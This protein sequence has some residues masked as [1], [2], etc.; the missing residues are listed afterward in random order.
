MKGRKFLYAAVAL[1][2][3]VLGVGLYLGYGHEGE[4][5]R[6]MREAEKRGLTT[7]V[8]TIARYED[9][10]APTRLPLAGLASMRELTRYRFGSGNPE[11]LGRLV[12]S[13]EPFVPLIEDYAQTKG[14]HFDDWSNA[15]RVSVIKSPAVLGMHGYMAAVNGDYEK[16]IRYVRLIRR[17]A[18]K[19][20]QTGIGEMANTSATRWANI[21]LSELAFRLRNQPGAF[22]RL[23][24]LLDEHPVVDFKKSLVDELAYNLAVIDDI[25]NGDMP[26]GYVADSDFLIYDFNKTDREFGRTRVDL[27]KLI[28]SRYDNWDNR[29]FAVD[30][31]KF[32]VDLQDRNLHDSLISQAASST[33]WAKR[34]ELDELAARC[35][36]NLTLA[37]YRH[38]METGKNATTE[39]LAELGYEVTDP[40]TDKPFGLEFEGERVH[41]TGLRGWRGFGDSK[42]VPKRFLTSHP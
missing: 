21:V 22:S 24:A 2:A 41:V 1:L 9:N 14:Q 27:L 33:A 18:D 17:T 13:T 23:D 6:L 28:I 29:Q 34:R 10:S 20:M 5:A 35:A 42:V 26:Y 39:Q 38:K 19:A 8:G 31:S 12:A 30:E 7:R 37:A 11:Q 32:S 3:G 40:W 25:Q 16:A 15:D 36:M 4:I